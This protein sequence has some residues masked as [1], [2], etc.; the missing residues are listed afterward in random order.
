MNFPSGSSSGSFTIITGAFSASRFSTRKFS[1]SIFSTRK[2]STS[3][4]STPIG[5]DAPVISSP[6]P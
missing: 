3:N 2:F 4:I 5:S 6:S 1:T